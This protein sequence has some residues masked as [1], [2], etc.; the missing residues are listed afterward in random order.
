MTPPFSALPDVVEVGGTAYPVEADFRL[1]VALEAAVLRRE[2]AV[3]G[4]LLWRFYRD[5]PPEDLGAAADRLLWFYRLGEED[6]Q[7]TPVG[8]GGGRRCYDFHQD[9][10][11][12]YSSF[13]QAY[14]IDLSA[15]GLH[16]W[17]FRRLMFGL[18]PDTPFMQRVHYRTA[19]TSGMSQKER[20][21]YAKLREAFALRDSRGAP[22]TLEQRNAW[23][24]DYVRRRFEEYEGPCGKTK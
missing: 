6:R 17:K 1:F 19:D 4:T 16:W 9:A 7:N 10:D 12:L 23:M 3:V 5:Q 15:A 24:K 21:R 11:A 13:F 22:M 14:R 18:P 20:R 8:P 2:E